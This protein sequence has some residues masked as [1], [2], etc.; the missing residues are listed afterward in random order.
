VDSG[1]LL[2]QQQ[3]N[4][5]VG[6]SKKPS[7]EIPKVQVQKPPAGSAQGPAGRRV[8]VKRFKLSAPSTLLSEAQL[9]VLLSAFRERENTVEDLRQA[10]DQVANRLRERGYAFAS[11]VV[12]QQEIVDGTVV[13]E[14]ALGKLSR[15][16]DGQP[17]ISLKT[18]GKSRLDPGRAKAVMAAAVSDPAGLNIGQIERGLLLLNDLPG[19]RG[20]GVV[21]PGREPG[22]AGLAV[23]LREGPVAAGWLGYDN[24]GSRSTGINR[25]TGAASLNDPSGR[26][27]LAEFNVAGSSGTEWMSASYLAPIGVSGLR[28]RIAASGMDYRVVESSSISDAKGGSTWLSAGLSYPMLRT[29]TANVY[30]TGA[31]DGKQFKD[32]V[33]GLQT[34]SRRTQALSVGVQGNR[35]AAPNARVLSYSATLTG[36]KLDRAAVPS[37]LAA[38]EATRRTQGSYA[39]WRA[40]GAWWEPLGVNFSVSATLAGQFASKN[41]DSSEKIYLGG[42]RGVR[43]YPIEEAGGDSGQILNLEGRWR[44]VQ[45]LERGGWDC[46]LFGFFDAGHVVINKNVWTGWN[47]GNPNLRNQYALKGWGLGIRFEVTEIA[48]L[49]LV[50]AR[51]IGDNPGQSVTGLDANGRSDKGRIWLVG[52]IFF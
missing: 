3:Q 45:A 20:T 41:L 7:A 15:E 37:D 44:A 30:V 16:A 9:N 28:G 23:D 5:P 50:G 18:D 19:I 48:K 39:V 17:S 29:Q 46:T 36:G 2:K 33:A 14:V 11:A 27:D 35:Q 13:I 12:P 49:D 31:M 38:D 8:F 32:K 26:G 22:T 51:K 43:A 4:A 24:F 34:S 1:A 42:P 47:T 52:T 10:S 40:T 6:P 21:V 25:A